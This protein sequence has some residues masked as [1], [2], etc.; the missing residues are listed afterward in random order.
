MNATLSTAA[1]RHDHPP[2]PPTSH[3]VYQARRV[4]LVDRL[5]LHLG[6][7]LVKWGRRPYPV[8]SR[9]QRANRIEL[10]LDRLERARIAE[11]TLRLL[12]P[13]R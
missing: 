7:A 9:E 5:A 4:G 13:P 1:G 2:Q 11:R 10:Q 12:L 3:P 6:I 8:E